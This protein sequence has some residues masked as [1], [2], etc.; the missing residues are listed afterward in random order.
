M[1]VPFERYVLV[2]TL[3]SF[4]RPS[5]GAHDDIV[6]KKTRDGWQPRVEGAFAKVALEEPHWVW[7]S[8]RATGVVLGD[9]FAD[10]GY[11]VD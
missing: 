6:Q 7:L 1:R 10:F 9:A 5:G 4:G 2:L 8:A 11:A 3:R